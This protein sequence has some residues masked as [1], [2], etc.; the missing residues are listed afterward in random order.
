MVESVLAHGLTEITT[1][2]P[3]NSWNRVR[4]EGIMLV[5]PTGAVDGADQDGARISNVAERRK[6]EGV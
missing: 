3:R 5:G 1:S 4:A 2:L 6:F